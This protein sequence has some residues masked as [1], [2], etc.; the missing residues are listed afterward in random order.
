MFRIFFASRADR[1]FGKLSKDLQQEI[2]DEIKKLSEN[3]FQHLHVK[4]IRETQR[5]YRLRFRRWRILFALYQKE[6]RIEIVDLF[7]KKSDQDYRKR[8]KLLK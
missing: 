7:L 6:K 8:T 4:K 5:G 3:P 1:Q 2:Y